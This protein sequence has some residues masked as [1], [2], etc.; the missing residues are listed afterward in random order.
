MRIRVIIAFLV[1]TLLPSLTIPLGAGAQSSW[2]V[3]WRRTLSP[4]GYD[5]VAELAFESRAECETKAQQLRQQVPPP[6]SSELRENLLCF[7][8]GVTPLASLRYALPSR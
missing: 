8:A 3:L 4:S 7:P 1:L 2:W 6:R 5:A